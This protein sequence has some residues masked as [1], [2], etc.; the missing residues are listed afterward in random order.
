MGNAQDIDYLIGCGE[1][2]VGDRYN[3]GGGNMA[4]AIGELCG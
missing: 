4:K 3:R 2:A 1:E